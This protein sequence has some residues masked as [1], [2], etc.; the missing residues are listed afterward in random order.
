M[1]AVFPRTQELPGFGTPRL[2]YYYAIVFVVV[3]INFKRSG[4]VC[5]TLLLSL[6]LFLAGDSNEV[7]S[8]P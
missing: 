8:C 4:L 6:F 3:M 7:D 5:S 2:A 1:M